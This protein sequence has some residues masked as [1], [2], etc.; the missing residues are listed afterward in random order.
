MK[1]NL[2][3]PLI[4]AGLLVIALTMTLTTSHKKQADRPAQQP[5]PIFADDFTDDALDEGKWT[6]CFPGG[7]CTHDENK[8]LQC[9]APDNITQDKGILYLTARKENKVCSNGTNYQYTSG[10][11][12][13]EGKF[14]FTYGYVE[15]RAKTPAGVGFWPTIWLLPTDRSWPPELDLLEQIGGVPDTNFMSVH[16][17]ANSD[18]K[19]VQQ[20]YQGPDFTAGFHTYGMDWQKDHVTFYVDG[21][22]VAG[23]TNRYNVPNKPMYLILNLAVGGSAT[24]PPDA[25]TAFPSSFAVDYVKV[26]RQKP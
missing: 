7:N 2:I 15:A 13:T 8:E 9:Y 26:W 21:K 17:G 1:Q 23:Y 20:T 4:A 6:S 22:A 10:L 14:S 19:F 18:D 5:A 11:V 3:L 24:P 12:Q 16:Y 25:H